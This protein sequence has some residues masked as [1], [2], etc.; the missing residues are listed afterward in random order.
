MKRLTPEQIAAYLHR[1]Y[2]AVDGLWFMKVEERW[3]FDAALDV[4][5]QVWR[6]QPKIQARKLKELTGRKEG[7]DALEYCLSA[8][9]EIEGFT[10]ET[11]RPRPD[12]LEYRISGCPWSALLERSGRKSLAKAVAERICPME[13]EVWAKEFGAAIASSVRQKMCGGACCCVVTFSVNL[14]SQPSLA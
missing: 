4:D 7:L 10:F 11:A 13:Y 9:L 8:K 12:I 2:T 1:S 6:I 14:P 3:G 5:E